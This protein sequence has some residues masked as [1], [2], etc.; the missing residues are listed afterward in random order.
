MH[1]CETFDAYL[2]PLLTSRASARKL[3]DSQSV[4][5]YQCEVVFKVAGSA[6]CLSSTCPASGFQIVKPLNSRS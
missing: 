1:E 3:M 2:E 5:K 4:S 6:K